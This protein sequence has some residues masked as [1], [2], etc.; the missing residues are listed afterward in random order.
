M[1]IDVFLDW[2][3]GSA[4]DLGGILKKV[5]SERLKLTSISNRGE[6]VWPNGHPETFCTDHWRCR[7]LSENKGESLN[8]SLI[9]ELLTKINDAGFDFI[10][11]EHLYNFDGI[12]GYSHAAS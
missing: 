2:S 4:D 9:I 12:P 10:K 8:R 11:T 3:N 1:G 7:Y 5:N 6:T